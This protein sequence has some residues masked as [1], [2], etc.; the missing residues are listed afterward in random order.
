ME[1][2]MSMGVKA[3]AFYLPESGA[4]IGFTYPAQAL[5]IFLPRWKGTLHFLVGVVDSIRA[6]FTPMLT[7]L[8]IVGCKNDVGIWSF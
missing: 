3:P 1:D 8:V 5:G 6:S 7:Q 2:K 4:S